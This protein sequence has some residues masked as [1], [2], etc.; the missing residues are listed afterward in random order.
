MNERVFTVPMV[1]WALCMWAGANGEADA[2][3]MGLHELSMLFS[4]LIPEETNFS[5]ARLGR[6]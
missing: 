6:L 4:T 3:K 2:H 5:Q 1:Q